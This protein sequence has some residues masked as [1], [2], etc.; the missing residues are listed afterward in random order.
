[1]RVVSPSPESKTV[2]LAGAPRSLLSVGNGVWVATGNPGR[3]LS[4]GS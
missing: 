4:V 1:V 3:V 2:D